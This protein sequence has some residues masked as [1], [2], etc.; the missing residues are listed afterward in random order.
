MSTDQTITDEVKVEL[1]RAQLILTTEIAATMAQHL[2][3]LYGRRAEAFASDLK[4]LREGRVPVT[5][6]LLPDP[7]TPGGNHAA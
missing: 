2:S 3:D 4:G 7:P 5:V 6:E 1:Y